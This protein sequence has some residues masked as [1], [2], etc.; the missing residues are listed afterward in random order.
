MTKEI[1]IQNLE[2]IFRKKQHRGVFEELT[3]M[4]NLNLL[5]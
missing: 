1:E 5:T 3:G 2:F 4:V